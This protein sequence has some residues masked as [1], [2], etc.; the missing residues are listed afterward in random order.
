M[1]YDFICK[2][3]KAGKPS[4]QGAY[5]SIIQAKPMFANDKLEFKTVEI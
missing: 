5:F 1:K 3:V 2:K 4:H